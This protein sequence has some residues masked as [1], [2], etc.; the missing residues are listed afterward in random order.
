MYNV[1]SRMPAGVTVG[2]SGLCCCL[3][4]LLSAINSLSFFDKFSIKHLQ[5]AKAI[6]KKKTDSVK[7]TPKWDICNKRQ[8][9]H[10]RKL[11]HFVTL[12]EDI[13]VLL[14]YNYERAGWWFPV[15]ATL[16]TFLAKF[17]TDS[18]ILAVEKKKCWN[19]DH[20]KASV[21]QVSFWLIFI[22]EQRS[23]T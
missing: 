18:F 9:D 17:K 6:E 12:P 4:C 10:S 1:F 23:S 11:T 3:P 21:F 2:D 15:T 16:T 19:G 13:V 8:F 14:K 7:T 20:L 22:L 5:F